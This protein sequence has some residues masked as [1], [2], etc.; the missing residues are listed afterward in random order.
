[1]KALLGRIAVACIL[2]GIFLFLDPAEKESF[3]YILKYIYVGAICAM[4]VDWLEN[5]FN[6]LR[7]LWRG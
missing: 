3:K 5:V 4:A 7:E 6:L 2:S 1:M